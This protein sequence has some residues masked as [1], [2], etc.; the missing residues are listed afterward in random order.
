[1]AGG[2]AVFDYNNDGRLDIFFT[3]GAE[4]PSLKKTSAKYWNRLFRNNGDGTFTDVTE[5]AG[6]AGSGYDTGVAVGDYNNDGYEDLFVGGVHHSALY[7]NNGDGTFTD[8]TAQAGLD[9][10]D[11]EYG[12]L[13]SV[14][15]VWLERQQ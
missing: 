10:P 15:G 9:K 11:T 2:V 12:P 3:N 8:V 5:K 6:L 7:R 13:W 1:M 4:M 14:G